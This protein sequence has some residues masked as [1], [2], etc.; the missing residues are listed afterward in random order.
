MFTILSDRDLLELNETN[1]LIT[2]FSTDNLTPNGYDLTIDSFKGCDGNSYILEVGKGVD[3]K[4]LETLNIPKNVSARISLRSSYIRRG[5]FAC[6]GVIDSGYFGTLFLRVTNF[7]E[8]PIEL[9][10]GKTLVQLQF[11]YMNSECILGY[12]DRSGNYQ[13]VNSFESQENISKKNF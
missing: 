2:P 9:N 12:A 5:I 13:N 10:V 4:I 3:I 11:M 1:P 7:G 6:F 8:E